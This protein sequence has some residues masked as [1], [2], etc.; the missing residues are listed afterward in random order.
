MRA[1]PAGLVVFFLLLYGIAACQAEPKVTITTQQGRRVSFEVEVADTPAK[2]ERGLQFR[3][4]LA[5]NRGMMF[6]FPDESQQSFWMKNTPIPLDMIFIDG[7]FRIVGI[8]EQTK[9]FSLE[10]RGVAAPSRYVLE[11]NGGLSKRH[12]IQVGDSVRFDGISTTP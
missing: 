5:E 2:R 9:P 4:E 12:G 8:V 3:R 11:I 1:T 6:I 7:R 10:A